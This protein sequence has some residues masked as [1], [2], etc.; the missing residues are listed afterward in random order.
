M[1]RVAIYGSGRFAKRFY[2]NYNDKKDIK[3]FIDE[4]CESKIYD[5]DVY[6]ADQLTKELIDKVDMIYICIE[7]REYQ[8]N[9]KDRLLKIDVN[10]SKI[11]SEIT[12]DTLMYSL[13]FP[14]LTD[15]DETKATKLM[16]NKELD[17][18]GWFG[19]ENQQGLIKCLE[20]VACKDMKV[21]EV[22]SWKGLSSSIISK[23]ISKYDGTLYSVDI[24]ENVEVVHGHEDKE[25]T[26]DV[27]DTFLDNM[28][29]LGF[30]KNIKP[31]KMSSWEAA[32]ILKDN[33]FDLVFIDAAHVYDIVSV[34]IEKFLPMVKKGGIICG[35]DCK[36]YYKNLPSEYIEKYKNEDYAP[37]D[38]G[39]KQ[40]YHCGVIKALYEQFGDDYNIELNS[41]FWWKEVK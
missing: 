1:E 14:Y 20:N 8:L 16:N 32:D 7:N 21:L 31:M 33:Q 12:P 27:F 9:A 3:F 11:D 10:Q 40:R 38:F 19:V 24:W 26:K 36:D 6:K 35:D 15:N 39:V 23:T 17:L 13:L 41:S 4:F 34:D 28:K 22:G 25:Q 5:L 29:I 30:N 2:E 18:Q 37:I